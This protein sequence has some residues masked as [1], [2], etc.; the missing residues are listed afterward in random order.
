LD[1]SNKPNTSDK[2]T[3]SMK[4]FNEIKKP[5]VTRVVQKKSFTHTSKNTLLKER[6]KEVNIR[7]YTDNSVGDYNSTSYVG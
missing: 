7:K 4:V 2:D 1:S 6:T 3:F 5:P